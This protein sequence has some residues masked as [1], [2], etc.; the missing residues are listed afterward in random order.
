MAKRLFALMSLL[1][2]MVL[3]PAGVAAAQ[4][5]NDE[6]VDA[7]EVIGLPFNDSVD[8]AEATVEEEEPTETCASFGNTVWYA[9]TLPSTTQ[10]AVDTAGSDYDT[11]VAVWSSD[12]SLIACNDDTP[13]GLESALDFTAEEDLTYFVQVGA[14]GG[15][16]PGQFGSTLVLSMSEGGGAFEPLEPLEPFGQFGPFGVDDGRSTLSAVAIGFVALWLALAMWVYFDAIELGRPAIAWAG[17][18]LLLGWLLLVPLFL[19]LIFRD[20]GPTRSVAPG[21]GR[22]LYFY[23]ADFSA[24]AVSVLGSL[25]LALALI[26][27]AVSEYDNVFREAMA[28][29]IAVI[30]VG[31][32]I[33]LFHWVRTNRVVGD[34]DGDEEFRATFLLHRAYLHAVFGLYGII[35]ILLTLWTIGGG[36]SSAFDVADVEVE[37]WIG[38]TGPLAVAV[39]VI[40]YHYWGSFN[41]RR[42]RSLLSRFEGP[43]TI[44][45]QQP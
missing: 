23:V 26:E 19:Y 24:L 7:T 15:I 9:L 28:S 40:A 20:R 44:S 42:Y 30:L 18:V 37:D 25:L 5:D 34:I 21:S 13:F 8:V 36:L 22:R 2:V 1:V 35:A 31:V 12:L 43:P 39:A 45:E 38:A 33:W 29:S 41:T 11:A 32:P 16:F 17:A 4:P 10:V 14:L 27:G 3:Q 6:F